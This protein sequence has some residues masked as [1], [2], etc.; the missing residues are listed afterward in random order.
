MTV[1]L[2]K[3]SNKRI[4]LFFY[5]FVSEGKVIT[6]VLLDEKVTAFRAQL[7]P[8]MFLEPSFPTIAGVNGNGAIVHYRYGIEINTFDLIS[9]S[10]P[11]TLYF[12]PYHLSDMSYFSSELVANYI[13]FF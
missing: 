2:A 9:V 10:F 7:S 6:E 12:I 1:T 8:G 5:F 4:L 13:T 3:Y 11:V